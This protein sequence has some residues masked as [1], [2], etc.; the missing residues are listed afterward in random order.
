MNNSMHANSG[1]Y[2][3]ADILVSPEGERWELIDGIAYDMMP[4]PPPRHQLVLGGFLFQF[5]NFLKGARCEAMLGPFDV[6]LPTPSEDG[7]TASTVVQPDFTVLCEPEKF[8][9][10]GYVGTPTLVVEIIAPHTAKKDLCDKRIKYAQVG[11]PEYWVV[12]P[13]DKV[14]LVYTLNAQGQYD[15]PAVYVDGEQAPVGVLPGL[16]IDLE[17]AFAD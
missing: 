15:A 12:F 9:E 16:V 14:L 5:Y 13:F 8:D 3:Y 1:N 2:T 7:I 17:S 10:H 11:V 4:T 6:R